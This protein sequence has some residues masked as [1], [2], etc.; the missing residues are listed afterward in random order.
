MN[1]TGDVDTVASIALGAASC[2]KEYQQDLPYW[3][4]EQLEN[5]GYGIDYEVV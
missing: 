4:F 5:G 2:C 3:L 1:F